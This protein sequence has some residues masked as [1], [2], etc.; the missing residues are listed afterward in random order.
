MKTLMITGPVGSGKSLVC[1]LLKDRGIPVYDCDAGAK[2][3]YERH[4]ELVDTLEAQL[5]A[6]L[7]G[8]DGKLDKPR[9][10]ALIFS[11][12]AAR[13]K[14]NSIVHPA[15][16]NDFNR[17]CSNFYGKEWVGIESALFLSP[18]AGAALECD[19]VL[20]V[21]AAVSIREGRIIAR[22][23]CSSSQ[24]RERIDSQQISPRDSRVS[25]V[26]NNEGDEVSLQRQLDYFLKIQNI[27]N[28]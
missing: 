6:S 4:P 11:D 22:D 7:R 27:D 10:A 20:Y 9:L 5:G 21:D 2:T 15:V 26:L 8:E 18:E 1:R 16:V 14:V 13:K 19:A 25:F 28:R 24:A 23:C 17:W 12:A 3:L